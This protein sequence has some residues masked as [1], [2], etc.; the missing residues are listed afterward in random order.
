[1]IHYNSWEMNHNFYLFILSVESDVTE[2]FSEPCVA[3]RTTLHLKCS[4]RK[5]IALRWMCGHWD[6]FCKLI[7]I[8]DEICFF[9][10]KSVSS[11][12]PGPGYLIRTVC[13]HNMLLW[14]ASLE[15]TLPCVL[16]CQLKEEHINQTQPGSLLS[17]SRR[18]EDERPCSDEIFIFDIGAIVNK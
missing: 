5:D 14:I 15:K 3:L 17:P 16:N 12:W 18:H 8:V 2:F 1:M 6:V 7:I 10:I 4:T 9:L 13:K 11:N